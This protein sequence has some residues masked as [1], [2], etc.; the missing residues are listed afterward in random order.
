VKATDP[1]ELEEIFA[2][3]ARALDAVGPAQHVA[4]LGK[5]ALLLAAELGDPARFDALLAN[6]RQDLDAPKS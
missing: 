1:A 2:A 4:F 5:L 3:L 6:A